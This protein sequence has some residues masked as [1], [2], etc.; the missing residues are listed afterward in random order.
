MKFVRIEGAGTPEDE[1][2]RG[3]R[4]EDGC[5]RTED[6]N[7]RSYEVEKLRRWEGRRAEDD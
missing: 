3:R 5:R 1:K 2:I 6:G 7:G 4:T